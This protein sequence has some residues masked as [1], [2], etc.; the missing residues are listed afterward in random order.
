M[1]ID[2]QVLA[3]YRNQFSAKI[4]V[5]DSV[6]VVLGSGNDE[7]KE[8][9]LEACAASNIPVLRRYGGGGTV[10]LY[11][12]C[13]VVS[14]GCWVHDPFNNSQF[15]KLMN[16][17]VIDSLAAEN[18][19]LACLS[20]AGISDI[21]AG[22]KKVAGT[23]MFR[24]RNYL[25]Y[26]ASMIVSLEI[27]LIKKSLKHPT[28]EPDYRKGRSHEDF[29][30]SLQNLTSKITTPKNAASMIAKGFER[31]AKIHL[32][33]MLI[34]PVESQMPALRARLDRSISGIS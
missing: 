2:D 29:L 34:E 5:P 22:Q 13:V 27:D 23:S 33:S 1:W 7:T 26:Q 6:T 16:Q 28:K 25:L 11:P 21:T 3:D 31:N 17:A 32:G 4:F 30:T 9:D 19:D 20:Q 24:S 15:F 14:A 12:G 10:V 18:D 8:V